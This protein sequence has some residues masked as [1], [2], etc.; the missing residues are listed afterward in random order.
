MPTELKPCPFCGSNDVGIGHKYPDFGEELKHF[1]VCNK[2]GSRTA[3]FR[4]EK[5][6][7]NIWDSRWAEDGT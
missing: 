4:S 1:V 7:V 5:T 6:A 2:C 3:N